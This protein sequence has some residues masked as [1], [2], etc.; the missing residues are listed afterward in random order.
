MIGRRKK[1]QAEV[2]DVEA[3]EVEVTE[4]DADEV[5]VAEAPEQD[6]KPKRQRGR[7]LALI[8]LP[9]LAMLLTAA[10]GYLKYELARAQGTDIARTEAMTAA[11]DIVAQ[12]LT[13]QPIIAEDQLNSA[14]ELTTG[15][16]HDEYAK[17]I[18]EVVIP[19]ANAKNV[20]ATSTVPAA[21]VIDASPN[22]V[23]TLLFVNQVVAVGDAEPTL[24][25]SRFQAT[26]ER[27]RGRWLISEFT[28]V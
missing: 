3:A 12:M 13:Y 27:E 22:R 28:P 11:K 19:G 17:Q 15:A 1:K 14:L 9:V 16:F 2:T 24:T 23:K 6:G 5:E 21:S 18:H 10:A 25:L 26:L 4:A 7:V 20:Y 8:V